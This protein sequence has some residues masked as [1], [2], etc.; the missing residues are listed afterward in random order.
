MNARQTA[1]LVATGILAFSSSVLAGA[2]GST[3][4]L[5]KD[6]DV[7][8]VVFEDLQCPDCR[9]VH[10]LLLEAAASSGV[11]LVIRD[12]PITRHAWAFPA[13]VLAG[14]F[15]AQSEALGLEFRSFIFRNQPDINPDN[16]RQYGEAFA[17]DHKLQL[18][19]DIDPDGRLA[20]RVQSD[21]DLG[22]QINLEY[23]P[24]IFVIGP[25][26]GPSH[27][28]EVTDPG[29]LGATIARMKQAPAQ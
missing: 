12:F 5:P 6:V 11:P 2:D 13:A 16:L 9:Q 23:V 1:S 21:V 29:Q 14:Y 3:L 25:A 19:P 27:A 18:P 10:P 28:V 24:L 20:A 8:I 4:E 15:T 17:Q 7:A 22:R 26:A